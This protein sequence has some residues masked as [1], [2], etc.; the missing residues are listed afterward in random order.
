MLPFNT[1]FQTGQSRITQVRLSVVLADQTPLYLTEEHVL[2]SGFVHDTSTT[3]DGEF[4]IGAAV[5]GK[6]TVIIDNSSNL[7]SGYD[8]RDANITVALGGQLS[9]GTYELIT[10]GKF[11]A[12][13]Y[14][15]DGSNI[16]LTAYDNLYKFDKPCKDFSISFPQTVSGLITYACTNVAEIS[17]A[18]TSIPNG[19]YVVEQKPESWENMTWH[20]VISYC[21]QIACCFA[22][23]LPDGRLFLS[24]YNTSFFLG[25]QLDGGTFGTQTTPYYDGAVADG[26]D[27]TYT[28][29]E[30][31]D[32]GSFGDRD[33]THYLSQLFD[34]TVD[35]D[36]VLITGVNVLLPVENNI[37]ATDDTQDYEAKYG[38]DGYRIHINN[39]PLIETTTQ[40]DSIA[41]YIYDI[42]AGMRFRPLDASILENPSIEAGDV[43]LVIDRL[44]NTYTCF[45]SRAIYTTGAAT[46]VSCDAASTMQNLK[47]RYGIAEQTRAMATRAFQKSVKTTDEA[48]D[49]V[50]SGYATTMGL[51]RFVDE[52]EHGNP[53][54]IY[55]NGSTLAASQIRWR[56]SAGAFTVS[57]DY[58]ATWNSALS[59]EGIAIFQEV[60]AV[61]VVADNI[62]SGTLTV[63]GNNNQRGRILIRDENGALRGEIDNAGASVTG[64]LMSYNNAN[65][66]A[67]RTKYGQTLI[68]SSGQGYTYETLK[69]LTSADASGVLAGAYTSSTTSSSRLYGVHLSSPDD[70]ITIGKYIPGG[71]PISVSGYYY[72]NTSDNHVYGHPETHEFIGNVR[73]DNATHHYNAIHIKNPSTTASYPLR[74]ITSSASDAESY[75]YIGYYESQNR[76]EMSG[77]GIPSGVGLKVSSL[78]VV[79]EK[80]RIVETKHYGNVGMNAF[81]TAS[82]HFADIGSGTVGED[83]IITIFFDPVYAE[84]IAINAE[85]QVFLTRTSE[86]EVSWVDKKSGYFIV[87]GDPG[88]TFDWMIVGHQKDYVTT[89]MEPTD[90]IEP[91]VSEDPIVEEETDAIDAVQQMIAQYNE[92]LEDIGDEY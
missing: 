31:Y 29:T 34:L 40:A 68:F 33:D 46:F 14:V 35:T 18:N 1:E 70:Y 78:G 51:N 72:V 61:K 37:D 64:I 6:I 50:L 28:E 32:G 55:G 69:N 62:V 12:E 88:A 67:T 65:G 21:A 83:G 5:T 77:V 10:I 19:S 85:Y 20:D 41:Y 43:A 13:Q 44:D 22:K 11:T 26:G 24:W 36:D 7:F 15:Y 4:T 9:D 45:I 87:H 8:F 63:G 48:I 58:G 79:G 80:L 75:A 39:N 30:Q 56:F 54:Y 82:A 81:E 27:F 38:T 74:W 49:Q 60:Y 84:T 3:V 73:F 92:E 86:A 17:L 25:D 16:T 47:A 53:I 76:F 52:D 57:N 59:S 2:L 91:R 90:S 42:I 66:Y 89:R 23:I 71:S